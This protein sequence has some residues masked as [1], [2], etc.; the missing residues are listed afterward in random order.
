MYFNFS[1]TCAPTLSPPALGQRTTAR[2]F[3]LLEVMVVVAILGILAAL[4]GPSFGPLI[5]RWRVRDATES[6]Q[7]AL[8][9]ARSEAIK[10]GGNISIKAKS[11]TDWGSGWQV[12]FNNSGTDE[13]LQNTDA[14]T[15]VTVSL[16][17][18]DGTLSIDRWG[19][20]SSTQLI[21]R[22]YPQ[23]TSTSNAGA[24]ALCIGTGGRIRRLPKGDSTCS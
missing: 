2:G 18:S 3:T 10:R 21:F 8:Y 15:R 23:G 7:S 9:Y 5:E 1:A 22:L 12:I 20:L 11:G 17:S 19:L 13:V 4:A 6:L 24:A 16:A 14:P